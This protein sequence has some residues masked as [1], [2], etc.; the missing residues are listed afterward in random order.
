MVSSATLAH[1]HTQKSSGYYYRSNYFEFYTA[2]LKISLLSNLAFPTLFFVITL[3]IHSTLALRLSQKTAPRR[4][5]PFYKKNTHILSFFYPCCFTCIFFIGIT[6]LHRKITNIL[7]FRCF[8]THTCWHKDT[9]KCQCIMYCTYFHTQCCQC[10]IR[11]CLSY[12]TLSVVSGSLTFAKVRGPA[13][14]FPGKTRLS[15]IFRSYFD[16]L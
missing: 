13:F 5:L 11:P 12:I 15:C 6:R 10:I 8:F 16:P 4:N 7:L 1:T 9:C 2:L 3:V 14:S